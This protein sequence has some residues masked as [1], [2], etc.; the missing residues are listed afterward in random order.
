MASILSHEAYNTFG[1]LIWLGWVAIEV[2]LG[3]LV[4]EM[5]WEVSWDA[6]VFRFV[7]GVEESKD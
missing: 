5:K 2:H 6:V 7:A 4:W 1:G 3:F